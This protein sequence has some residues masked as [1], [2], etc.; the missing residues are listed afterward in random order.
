[1]LFLTLYMLND[2]PTKVFSRPSIPCHYK[3]YCFI[4]SSS[5]IGITPLNL[6]A[7]DTG[8]YMINH[9]HLCLRRTFRTHLTREFRIFTQLR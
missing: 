9:N 8:R 3:K 2:Q 5:F 7:A 4:L 6:A 1:M